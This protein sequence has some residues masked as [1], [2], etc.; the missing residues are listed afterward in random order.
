MRRLFFPLIEDRRNSTNIKIIDT[1]ND[2][3]NIR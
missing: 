2:M 3:E 1:R